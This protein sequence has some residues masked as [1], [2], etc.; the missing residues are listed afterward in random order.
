MARYR[1]TAADGRDL[2]TYEADNW[3]GVLAQLDEN[4]AAL[5]WEDWRT[6]LIE[7]GGLP[8]MM[9]VTA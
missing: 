1:L 5:G 4:S 2:G 9:T 6:Y 8:V 7:T 3:T